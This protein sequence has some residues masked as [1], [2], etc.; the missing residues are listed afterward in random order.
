MDIEKNKNIFLKIYFSIISVISL[1]YFTFNTSFIVD[2]NQR[3]ESFIFILF[4]IGIIILNIND[5]LF[6]KRKNKEKFIEILIINILVINIIL[7]FLLLDNLN[8]ILYLENL[9]LNYLINISFFLIL[10]YIH[11]KLL[12]ISLNK[13]NGIKKE[14]NFNFIKENYLFVYLKALLKK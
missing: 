10:I 9:K 6:Y 4:F 2:I 11:L 3:I 1:I 13:I 14:N 7:L 8:T 5:I 12:L